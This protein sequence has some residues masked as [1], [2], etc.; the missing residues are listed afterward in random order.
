MAQEVGLMH[1]LKNI[2]HGSISLGDELKTDL[3]T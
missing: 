1:Y 2:S 3:S